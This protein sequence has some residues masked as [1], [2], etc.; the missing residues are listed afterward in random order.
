MK[1]SSIYLKGFKSFAKPTK[2]E[3]SKS[4]TGIVGPNGS[5]KSNIVDAIKWIFGTQSMKNI[6]ADSSEDVIFNGSEN[7]APT[8]SAIVEVS[9][10]TDEG[11]LKISRFQSRESGSKYFINNKLCR[12]MDIKEIFKGT[13]V[14]V[15]IYSIVG[16]GQVDKVVSSSPYELRVLLEEAAGTAVYREKKREALG[17]LTETET[18]LNRLD[19]IIFELNKRKKSLYLKAKR[20]EKYLEYSEKQK[21][22]NLLYYGNLRINLNKKSEE[23]TDSRNSLS[24]EIKALQKQLIENETNLNI[25]QKEYSEADKE[26]ESMTYQ[27]E[28]YKKRQ[29]DLLDLKEMYTRRLNEKENLLIEASTKYDNLLRE[30]ENHE[31]RKNEINMILDSVKKDSEKLEV[32]ISE[33]EEERDAVIKKYS[34]EEQNFFQIQEELDTTLKRLSKVENNLERNSNTI[35][36]TKKRLEL[37]QNQFSIKS[38]RLSELDEEIGELTSMGKERSEKQKE[39]EES[40]KKAKGD[41]NE[42]EEKLDNYK[43]KVSSLTNEKRKTDVEINTLERHLLEYTGFS[44]TIQEVFKRKEDFEGLIDVVANIIEVPE[45]LETAISVLLGGRMQD[46]VVSNTIT[47]RRVIDFLKKHRIGRVTMLPL[48][49]INSDFKR[50]RKAENHPGFVGYASKL[51]IAEEKYETVLDFLFGN[52]IIVESFD[53]AVQIR[54]NFKFMG[55]Q[56]SLDGQLFSARGSITGGF[57]GKEARTDLIGRTRKVDEL[58]ELSKNLTS[59][60]KSLEK[61]IYD[62]R[63]DI[64]EARSLI[65]LLNEELNEVISKNA[66]LN[67]TLQELVKTRGELQKEVEELDKLNRN[68]NETLN[69]AFTSKEE[70]EKEREELLVKKNELGAVVKEY[71]TKMKEEKEKLDKLQTDLIDLKFRQSTNSERKEQYE[72]EIRSINGKK[73]NNVHNIMEYSANMKKYEEETARFKEQISTQETELNSIKADIENLFGSMKFQREGK[74]EHYKKLQS[75]EDIIKEIKNKREDKREEVHNLDLKIQEISINLNN[76]NQKLENENEEF[77]IIDEERFQ[78]V[79][80]ELDD[81]E[82][83]MKFLGSVDLEVI[84]EYKEVEKEYEELDSQKQDLENAKSKLVDLIEKTDTEAKNLFAKTFEEVDKYF[85]R[86][87]S[88]LFN[89]GE[90]HLK[91]LPGEDLLESGLEISVRRPGRKIQKLQ[92]LSGGE[93]ALVGIA[94][95]FSLLNIKPS[96]FYILDEVDAPLDDFNAERFSKMLK[97]HTEDTQFLI[98]T[99]NKIIMNVTQMLHGVTMTDGVSQIIPAE[100]ELLE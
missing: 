21:S 54:Q 31:N 42:L 56:V 75:L 25:L 73:E 40:L 4:T 71:N 44:R 1:L 26:I 34:S 19:D 10:Y 18:N 15:D 95:V 17:K 70:L 57:V 69:K 2:I 33:L 53:D 47:A 37:I 92:L 8:N 38:E 84:N 30:N 89:G 94:F 27:L 59:E 63:N 88:E 66:S 98:I 87:F 82:N 62:T 51:L 68:Y 93:K 58:K 81:I 100:L 23:L 99:H 6:R 85:N 80:S 46:I 91:I 48:D 96:P 72:N 11:I 20:A 77:E 22:L 29:N 55:R 65:R 41:L 3:I 97:A 12:R 36:D 86:Y 16:Q 45:K 43:E 64:M 78:E 49:T 76:V 7:F 35:E 83:K 74:D 9:F 79:K 61:I 39:L 13:G 32:E 90:G 60:L 5:G 50:Y 67:R 52:S 14:G 24:E 28:S